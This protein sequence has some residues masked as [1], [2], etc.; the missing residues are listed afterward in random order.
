MRAAAAEAVGGGDGQNGD[1]CCQFKFH[2]G[3]WL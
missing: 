3:W 1:D 2:G